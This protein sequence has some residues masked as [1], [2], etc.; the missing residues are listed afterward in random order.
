MNLIAG[1]DPG[2]GGA[3]ALLCV[4]DG[5]YFS[6]I[7]MPVMAAGPNA[8]VKRRVNA[9]A[10]AHHLSLLNV[11]PKLGCKIVHAVIE[12]VSSRPSEGVCSVFSFGHSAGIVEGVV[13]ALQIPYEL[14]TPPEW[15]KWYGLSSDKEQSRTRAIQLYPSAPLELRK[16]EGRAEAILLTRYGLQRLHGST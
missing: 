5:S 15:K 6:V 9:T 3:I 4:E 7:D 16:H 14:I 2:L 8:T 11:S 1:I 12:R 13:A 10:I